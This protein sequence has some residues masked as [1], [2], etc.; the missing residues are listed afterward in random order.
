M[1]SLLLFNTSKYCQYKETLTI[2][3]KV[4]SI[5]LQLHKLYPAMTVAELVNTKIGD[6]LL[7]KSQH[8]RSGTGD[9]RHNTGLHAF[10]YRIM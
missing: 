3:F 9:W 7:N 4:P 2:H 1:T 6:P 10:C 5:D 8:A